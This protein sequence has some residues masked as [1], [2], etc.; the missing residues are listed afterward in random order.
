MK[1]IFISLLLLTFSMNIHAKEDSEII[2]K[3]LNITQ[4]REDTLRKDPDN[5]LKLV[6]VRFP[7]GNT[8][9][10]WMF[11]SD[12][13]SDDVLFVAEVPKS[14]TENEYFKKTTMIY[15][16]FLKNYKMGSINKKNISLL[17]ANDMEN[18]PYLYKMSVNNLKLLNN[19]D[20][21]SKDLMAFD[22]NEGMVYPLKVILRKGKFINNNDS[23]ADNS[24]KKKYSSFLK[25]YDISPLIEGAVEAWYEKKK[26]K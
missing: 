21:G 9:Q 5:K 15:R 23:K 1:N 3:E 4:E 14:S 8:L 16:W 25:S 22:D 7:D 6:P 20:F 17:L 18:Y 12:R 26:M 2:R 24:I 13:F 10:M 19:R 11:F